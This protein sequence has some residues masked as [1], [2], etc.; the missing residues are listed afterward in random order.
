[1]E[2]ALT[3]VS[4]DEPRRTGYTRA[5]L[6][7]AVSAWRAVLG[8]DHVLVGQ[9]DRERYA[10][11]TGAGVGTS[12]G[13]IVRPVST[14]QVQHVVRVA[15]HHGVPVHPISR[16]KNWGYG[17]ACAPTPGQVVLDLGLMNR[18][19]EV[20]EDLCYAVIEPGVSQGQLYRYLSERH[21]S[22]W[23]DCTGAGAEASVV[24]NVL[25]RGFGHTRY[26]DRGKATCGMQ[27]VL[28]DG[29]VLETGFGRY[30]QNALGYLYPY[31]V[32]P[33]LDGLFYQSNLGV[34][35]RLG[36]WLIPKPESFAAFFF[37]VPKDGDLS[38][39]VD[40]LAPL[41]RS[42]L[43]QSA[44]HIAND[45][46]VLSSRCRYP[47][48]MTG[49]KT[50]LPDEVRAELRRRW[51]VEPWNGL[52]AIYGTRGTVRATAREVER[53]MSGFP[54]KW[55]DDWRLGR[56]KLAARWLK[57]FGLGGQMRGVID[58]VEPLYG[59]LKGQPTEE[60][61][62]GMSWRVRGEGKPVAKDP[63]DTHAGFMWVSPVLPLLGREAQALMELIDPIYREYGFET[64]VTFTMI[65]ERAM[66]CVS[67]VAFDRRAEE[68]SRKAHACYEALM[69]AVIRAGYP[70]YR[71][72]LQ[73]YAKLWQDGD[74]YWEVA[75]KLKAALDPGGV[76]SPGRYIPSA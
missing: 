43:V 47:W 36:V 61:L 54:L 8:D 51:G 30:P 33:G 27:V 76:I 31:G 16:G 46:R 22:L 64:L 39:V 63:L 24:G 6:D 41:K 53:A 65:S 55:L 48:D 67:N 62:A 21:P 35:T 57:V 34:V 10:R 2:D 26:G 15:T 71:V 12:P 13:A 70:P 69:D 44:V 20:R 19:V 32:G 5:S 1:M 7:D 14:E 45:L 9:E 42:G 56:A 52:G 49:G 58:L 37:S 66:V 28:S 75:G 18:I 38:A 50:P 23:M 59:L 73:G 25:E 4:R 74:T 40:R 17:D 72:G 3:N 60:P 11:T 68:E 29:Q